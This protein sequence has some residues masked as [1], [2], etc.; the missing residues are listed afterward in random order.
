MAKTSRVMI[1]NLII[2]VCALCGVSGL[3]RAA[4]PLHGPWADSKPFGNHP[5]T[6]SS[7]FAQGLL[8]PFF[9]LGIQPG[10]P[11]LFSLTHS[12]PQA[13]TDPFLNHG[14]LEF[15]EYAHHLK[16]GLAGRCGGVEPLLMQVKIDPQGVDLG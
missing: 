14:S 8:D 6:W 12:P 9:Q 13:S 16:Q 5:H 4:D 15:G 7:G 11:K 1:R 10:P 2:G 3:E